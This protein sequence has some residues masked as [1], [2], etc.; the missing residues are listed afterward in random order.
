MFELLQKQTLFFPG[1]I[2][3]SALLSDRDSGNNHC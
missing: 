1:S 2:H 3:P